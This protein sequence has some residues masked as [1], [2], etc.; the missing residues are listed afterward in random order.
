MEGYRPSKEC[1]R[2]LTLGSLHVRID[3]RRLNTR[4]LKTFCYRSVVV[5]VMAWPALCAIYYDNLKRSHKKI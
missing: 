2:L 3:R 5:Q 1:N 4:N